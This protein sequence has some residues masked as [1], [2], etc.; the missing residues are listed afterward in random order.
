MLNSI[1]GST[2]RDLTIQTS[3]DPSS[4][5]IFDQNTPFSSL[6][7]VLSCMKGLRHTTQLLERGSYVVVMQDTLSKMTLLRFLAP[8]S[9]EPHPNE[10]PN[11]AQNGHFFSLI[12][13][14]GRSMMLVLLVLPLFG[15]TL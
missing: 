10:T 1:D 15:D 7:S 4:Q 8:Q 11:W 2:F 6:L 3:P 9:L 5:W 14:E 13:G 12:L